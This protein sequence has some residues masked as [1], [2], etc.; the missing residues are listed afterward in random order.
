MV[1]LAEKNRKE[2]TAI[3]LDWKHVDTLKEHQRNYSELLARCDNEALQTKLVLNDRNRAYTFLV[4]AI[5]SLRRTAQYALW[6]NPK[7]LRGYASEYFRKSSRSTMRAGKDELR[8]T[9]TV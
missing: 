4:A 9:S 8:G 2:L 5:D 3:G 6:D 1:V 7:R